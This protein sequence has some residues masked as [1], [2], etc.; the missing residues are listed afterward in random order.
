VTTKDQILELL[1]QWRHWTEHESTAL[2]QENWPAVALAQEEK[3]T[4]Q[5]RIAGIQAETPAEPRATDEIQHILQELID[6]EAAN[7]AA[8]AAQ[9]DFCRSRRDGLQVAKRNVHRI[10]R[11]YAGGR[12]AAWQSY[13]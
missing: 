4:L 13:S 8:L 12:T 1:A 9:L 6:L 2:K 7:D 11:S 10:H 5:S 3:R